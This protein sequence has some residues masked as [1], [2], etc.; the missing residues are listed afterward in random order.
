MVDFEVVTFLMV[1]FAIIGVLCHECLL[2]RWQYISP[3]IAPNTWIY[4][5]FFFAMDV[6][7]IDMYPSGIY[8]DFQRS[9]GT[10]VVLWVPSERG[11]YWW[12]II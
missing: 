10:I 11:T 9:E 6:G 8:V 1:V 3:C 2:Y 4:A 12:S 7:H 5:I